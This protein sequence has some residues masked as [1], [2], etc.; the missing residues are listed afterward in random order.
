MTIP[1][2]SGCQRPNDK[3]AEPDIQ[4]L[5]RLEPDSAQ[6]AV[7]STP[8]QPASPAFESIDIDFEPDTW[9]ALFDGKSLRGWRILTEKA[10]AG[11]ASVTIENGL[12]ILERGE[13]QTGI[14]WAGDFPRENYEVELDAMR[15]DGGD[16]FC[17]MTFP[18]GNEP[19][20]LIVGGW[21]GSV[22]GLSNVDGMHAAENQTTTGVFFDNDRWY[23]I[24]LRVTDRIEVWI[25][26][27]K[28]IDLA[29]E[30]HRFDVW[31][32]QE[33]AQPFGIATWDTGA[34]LRN[35]RVRKL[36]EETVSDIQQ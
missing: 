9:H 4:V 11:H 31:W 32:E 2:A 19:C 13:L 8:D 5:E 24:R 6:P 7:R 18:V 16:F 27:E 23:H 30:G 33:P 15:I 22:V 20:T 25:D 29:R 21:G 36:S 26:D 17:G 12:I 14:A 35:I 28:K 1:L 3:P 34:A 10:F